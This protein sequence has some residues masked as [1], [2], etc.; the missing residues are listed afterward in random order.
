M[1]R[2]FQRWYRGVFSAFSRRAREKRAKL[3]FEHIWVGPETKLLDL[4]GGTGAHVASLLNGRSCCVTVADISDSDLEKARNTF[5]YCV[6]KLEDASAL[7]FSDGEFDVVFCSSVLEHVT[8]PKQH[9]VAI[10]KKS[11]FVDIARKHQSIFAREIMRIGRAY[12]VQTPYRYFPIESH[13][14]MPAIILLLRR[15]TLRKL[16]HSVESWWPKRTI[17][18]WHLLTKRSLG[19][20]FPDAVIIGERWGPFLKSIIAVRSSRSSSESA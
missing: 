6:V 16:L 3:F 14:W 18:D 5:G 8:G 20:L 17:L 13:T 11:D 19:D 12:F 1:S 9:V 7:P 15:P 2:L 4:G 10:D